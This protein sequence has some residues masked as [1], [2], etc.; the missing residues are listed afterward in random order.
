MEE[1]RSYKV[2]AHIRKEPDENGVYK[3]YIGITKLKLEE[4]W[5]KN[6]K[7][8]K[9]KIKNNENNINKEN[10]YTHFYNA[11]LKY[12]WDGFTH[13][14]LLQNLTREE[15]LNWEVKLIKIYESS[16]EYYGYNG[17]EGGE[18]NI[19]NETTRK[20]N[21][22]SKKG[23][24]NPMYGR[25]G[26]LNPTYGKRGELNP[27]FKIPRTD[28]VKKKISIANSG[29]NNGMYGKTPWNKGTKGLTRANKTSFKK[30]TKPKNSIMVI[31]LTNKKIYD[32]MEDCIKDNK[33]SRKTLYRHCNNLIL[34][35][36]YM[37]Y[38]DWVKIN[39]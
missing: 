33:V 23:I 6:G 2:Y 16:N 28:E 37:Y 11:I 30:G 32:S 13:I 26:K 21:S 38:E 9:Y 14:L 19:P 24:K 34:S 18:H 15:A 5:G 1:E 10:K 12:G 35:P 3:R 39:S 7:G 29:K 31:K 20:K 27:L 17:T 8:Y 4:R 25:R 36:E 22:E